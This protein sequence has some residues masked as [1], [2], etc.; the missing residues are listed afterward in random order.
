MIIAHK[1]MEEIE[2]FANQM[3]LELNDQRL[4]RLKASAFEVSIEH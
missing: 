2:L 4:D 1:P 3:R